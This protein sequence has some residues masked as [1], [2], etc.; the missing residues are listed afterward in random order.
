MK[1][2]SYSATHEEK[3][4]TES[5]IKG[6]NLLNIDI[7]KK[8]INMFDMLNRNLI[9]NIN[10]THLRYLKYLDIELLK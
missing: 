8:Y 5:K 4:N 9:F 7:F 2:D 3:N 6:Q 1:K 10:V